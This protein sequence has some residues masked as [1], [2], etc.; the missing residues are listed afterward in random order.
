MN[1]GDVE[2]K[3][4]HPANQEIDPEPGASCDHCKTNCREAEGAPVQIFAIADSHDQS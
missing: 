2:T 1:V 4:D 3:P